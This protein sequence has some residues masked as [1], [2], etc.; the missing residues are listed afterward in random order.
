MDPSFKYAFIDY[1][2]LH[3]TDNWEK[4]FDVWLTS[5]ADIIFAFGYQ[6]KLGNYFAK[7]LLGLLGQ[8]LVCA[9]KAFMQYKDSPQ[10]EDVL[11]FTEMFIKEQVDSLN[12][13]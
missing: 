13:L 6:E 4:M 2:R 7:E 3:I 11:E 1:C 8:N 10:L 9:I 12:L 5:K